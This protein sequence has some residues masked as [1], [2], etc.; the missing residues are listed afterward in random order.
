MWCDS[1][2]DVIGP[3]VIWLEMSNMTALLKAQVWIGLKLMNEIIL[4]CVKMKYAK[5]AKTNNINKIKTFCI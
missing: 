4:I 3:G 1:V 5:L 2:G